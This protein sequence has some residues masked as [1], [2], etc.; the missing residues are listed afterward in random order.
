LAGISLWLV[1]KYKADKKNLLSKLDHLMQQMKDEFEKLKN[2]SQLQ[3][4]AARDGL[5]QKI[6]ELSKKMM[7]QEKK[8]SELKK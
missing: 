1:W 3:I 2:D 4:N 5:D 6:S 8:I 7:D